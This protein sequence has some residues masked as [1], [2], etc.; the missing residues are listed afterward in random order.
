DSILAHYERSKDR[1]LSLEERTNAVNRSW[2]LL[3][4][5]LRDSL[6]GYVLYQ[7]SRLHLSSREYDSLLYYHELFQNLEPQLDD[8]F[9]KARQLYLVGFY[10]SEIA[11]DYEKGFLN[12]SKS[13]DLYGLIR[14]SIWVG[15]NLLNMGT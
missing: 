3:E 6:F 5:N 7:K 4:G 13:R 9:N 8:N 10:F 1:E 12:F 14:D 15:R 2:E 11:K